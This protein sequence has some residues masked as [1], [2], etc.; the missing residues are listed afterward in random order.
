VATRKGEGKKNDRIGGENHQ[1][2]ARLKRICKIREKASVSRM[3]G[4]RQT[5]P[6]FIPSKGREGMNAEAGEK[7]RRGLREVLCLT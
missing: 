5:D 3:N 1:E 6:D 4:G 2:E 7:V